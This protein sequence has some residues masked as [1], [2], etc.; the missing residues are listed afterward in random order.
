MPPQ[1]DRPKVFAIPASAPFSAT[2]ARGLL[3][4]VG[5][6]PMALADATIYLPT[7]RAARAVAEIFAR[8]AGGAS[9]LPDFR[10]LG[11][12]DE[13]ELLL[14]PSI[15]ALD[16]KPAIAPLDRRMQLAA[17]IRRWSHNRD[18]G[19]MSFVQASALAK[20]LAQVMD[21]IERQGTDLDKLDGLAPIA[22]ADHW[23][24][25]RQFLLLM[26]TEWPKVLAAQ[27]RV[28]P[29][30]HRNAALRA[31]AF[32]LAHFR[33]DR[34]VIAA[35]STGSIPATAELLG[36]I[37]RLPK[38]AVVLPG[39]DRE[40]DAEAWE[41]VDAGH[42][43]FAL[44]QLLERIGVRRDQV[45]DWAEAPA[46]AERERLVREVL[47]PAPTTDAWR[48]LAES[49]HPPKAAG[50]SLLEAADPAEE[51]ALIALMLREALETKDLQA[52]LVTRDRGL[53]RRVTAELGRWNIAIDDSAGQPLSRTPTGS[54]LCLLAEAADEKF[55]PVPL[56][57]LLKHPLAAMGGDAAA[58]RAKARTLDLELRGPRPDSGLRG[59][60][61]AI[62]DAPRD[63]Q[64]WFAKLA[65]A[66][67]PLE[68]V[69][70]KPEAALIDLL[71]AH[72][73]AA[74]AL[75]AKPWKG[76]DGL[77]ASRFMRAWSE[78]ATGLPDIETGS[79]APMIRAFM[80]EVPVRPAYGR[81]P[82]LAI[83]G[84]LEARLQSYDLVILGGL[85]E[86]SWPAAAG[87]DPWFSRPMRKTL[88]LEQPERAIGLSAHDFAMLACQPRV[89]L[90]R[91]AKSEGTPMVASRWVQR[92]QQLAKGLGIADVLAPPAHIKR[93]AAALA[94]AGR[95]EPAEPP[96]P[97]PAVAARPRRLSVTE[98]ET[99]LRD[100]Y[101]IYARHVLKLR[102]LDPLDDEIGPMER[103]TALHKMLELFVRRY[104]ALPPDA[105][106]KLAAIVDEVLNERRTPKAT[107]AVW[108]PRFLRAAAWF[109]EQERERSADVAQSFVEIKG[110]MTF[111]GP[112]GEFTLSGK[113]DRIDRLKT[114]GGAIIDYK[115]GAPPSQ[116]QVKTHLAPQL[117]LEGAMLANGGF[118]DIGTLTPSEL[119]YVRVS[120][121]AEPGKYCYVDADAVALANEA[122]G[123][124]ARRIAE[125]DRAETGYESRVAP[126][127][128]DIAGD[129]DHLARVREWSLS[130]WGGE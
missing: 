51:A 85:N 103:G 2:L 58:F 59:I 52:A 92:L 57:A 46:D 31:L 25:V 24:E 96:C 9:L 45:G 70:A 64:A 28:S 37:A 86:G 98:V 5:P 15:D 93:I 130:G 33:P 116:K 49:T 105:E 102:P 41:R 94:D 69:I 27:D 90:T 14:D 50:L 107:L 123:R 16:L 108:R 47:R 78:A 110:E 117:P 83:L 18:G 72:I 12:V 17:I 55:A 35:G 76:P 38:G 39:L 79:Y 118:K 11:D 95:P 88:G 113:A 73:A 34:P 56:L 62:G 87:E 74:D 3:R 75:G 101:A 60:A 8:E 104:P 112:A 36:V 66:L 1:P 77:A 26:A 30:Q 20:A 115:T 32:R 111:Q 63:L 129:Y 42:P 61:A 97:R 121:A 6:E 43:Q 80:D 22:L 122:A 21:E 54:F 99:W 40:L 4:R 23:A 13:D 19:A 127:R 100:P 68:A 114:G 126:F 44:K 48:A 128:S 109:V 91:A 125:F 29:E 106:A 53:A 71:R 89:V 81:H 119:L 82:R 67:A 65:A 124:L 120:G 10:P 84:P 7:R